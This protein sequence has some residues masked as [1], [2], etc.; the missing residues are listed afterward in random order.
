MKK[1]IFLSILSIIIIVFTIA[2]FLNLKEEKNHEVAILYYH[3]A[4]TH[5]DNGDYDKTL[6]DI[7]KSIEQGDYKRQH[8]WILDEFDKTKEKI[9]KIDSQSVIAQGLL[10]EWCSGTYCLRINFDKL[11][12]KEKLLLEIES[13]DFKGVKYPYEIV[14]LLPDNSVIT[15]VIDAPG[16]KEITLDIR[17]IELTSF[18]IKVIQQTFV[19]K[20]IGLNEDTRELSYIIKSI[21]VK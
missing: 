5:Y 10:N 16:I 3:I 14:F 2:L 17:G 19:P 7:E 1:Y 6:S 21:K 8:T 20:L 12:R 11:N 15:K 4:K 9:M 13:P 18:T